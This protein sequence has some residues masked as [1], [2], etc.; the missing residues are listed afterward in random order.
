MIKVG[1]I[2][3]IPRNKM[4]EL[5]P[6]AKQIAR[7]LDKRPHRGKGSSE[8]YE[9]KVITAGSAACAQ[10]AVKSYIEQFDGIKGYIDYNIEKPRIG[11]FD[12]KRYTQDIQFT[13]NEF[14]G[15]ISVKTTKIGNSFYCWKDDVFGKDD[16]AGG[17]VAAS[18][19]P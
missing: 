10:E 8:T 14:N 1:Q 4:I 16:G 6:W 19:A 13:H 9:K 7:V 15:S 5:Y 18:C 11:K 17:R 3:Q 12:N 2:Y